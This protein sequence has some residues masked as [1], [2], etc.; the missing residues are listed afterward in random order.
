VCSL[1]TNEY[2][3]RFPR[4]DWEYLGKGTLVEFDRLGLVHYG[5]PEPELDL[6]ERHDP[7]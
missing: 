5:V 6:L 2:S 1:D 3:E 4:S 7:R